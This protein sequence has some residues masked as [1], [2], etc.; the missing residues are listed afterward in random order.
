MTPERPSN[1]ERFEKAHIMAAGADGRPL[2]VIANMPRAEYYS[3]EITRLTGAALNTSPVQELGYLDS[4]GTVV[5]FR[6]RII[7]PGSKLTGPYM[8]QIGE[9]TDAGNGQSL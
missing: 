9:Y 5:N 6:E 4:L 3:D 2:M 7:K 1:S 8:H